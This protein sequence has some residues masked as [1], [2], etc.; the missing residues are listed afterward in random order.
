MHELA[1][2][3]QRAGGV[4]RGANGVGRLVDVQAGEQR[5]PCVER[6]VRADGIGHFEVVRTAKEEVF[7]AVARGDVHE[8][9]AGFGGDELPG[10]TGTSRS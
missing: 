3:E 4:E 1:A 7:L 2:P 6:A 8:A 10:N 9:G 5:H